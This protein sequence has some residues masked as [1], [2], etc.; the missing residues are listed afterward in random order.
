MPF[1][2]FLGYLGHFWVPFRIL[3]DFFWYYLGFLG[4]FSEKDLG[5]LGFFPQGIF[6]T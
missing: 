6:K 1:H 4:H 2:S 3:G 5:F